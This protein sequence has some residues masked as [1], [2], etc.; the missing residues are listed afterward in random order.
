M[1]VLEI[2]KVLYL[3]YW[4]TP[5][6]MCFMHWTLKYIVL[7]RNCFFFLQKKKQKIHCAQQDHE[8]I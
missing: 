4:N 8:V 7:Q 5:G 1:G 3:G 6:S 2:P